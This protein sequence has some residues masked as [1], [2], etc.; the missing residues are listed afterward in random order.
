MENIYI[1]VAFC[2]NCGGY[3]S[4]A[5]E[6]LSQ[7]NH[8]E[9]IDH[10]F[11]HGE[12]WFTLNQSVF[13]TAA[14]MNATEVKR[15]N[16][17]DHRENDQDYCLCAKKIQTVTKTPFDQFSVYSNTISAAKQSVEAEEFY[18]RDVYQLCYNFH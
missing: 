5:P 18:F 12:P 7:I 14:L 3:H 16:L 15:M 17:N 13:E 2:K 8:P 1:K 4:S 10:Y 11:Y 6:N 9:I